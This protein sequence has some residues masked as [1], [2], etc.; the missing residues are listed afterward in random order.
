MTADLAQ[1]LGAIGAVLAKRM[2]A[3]LD[4]T[5]VLLESVQPSA[6]YE[7]LCQLGVGGHAEV[8][9]GVARGR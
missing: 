8:L 6:R 7:I 3:V 2:P 4:A 9:L 1:R 5:L